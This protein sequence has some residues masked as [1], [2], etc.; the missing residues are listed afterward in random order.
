MCT[1][2]ILR[3][4]GHPW[5]VLL[6]ANRDEMADRPWRSPARHWP[7]QTDVVAGL[8]CLAGGTWFGLNDAGVVA[9]VLNRIGTL[10][11]EQGRAS[12]GQLPLLALQHDKARS[13]A[14]AIE[15]LTPSAY[16]PFNMVILDRNHGYWLRC[17]HDETATGG[18]IDAA[19]LPT[20]LAML[21]AHDLNDP[22]SP[23]MRR[24]LP[25]FQ[26][27][28]IPDPDT[29][30]WQAWQTI[31]AARDHDANAG[32]GGAM[33]VVTDSGFGTI[34]ASLLALAGDRDRRALWRFAAG[35]PGEVPFE[36]VGG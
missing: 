24:Y 9:G 31:L 26:H 23:R 35:R 30:D 12:R 27:A 1:V 21:T 36:P 6:A 7:A 11:P 4:P 32:P 22:A 5:P 29:G 19:P 18:T 8:D 17:R 33:T 10:G 2:V 14:A 15:A 13:A 28:A 20:G 25:Q 16:R 3:R 34:C